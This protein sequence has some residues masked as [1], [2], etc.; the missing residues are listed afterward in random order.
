MSNDSRIGTPD[1][2]EGA[3]RIG[4]PGQCHLVE[5]L[6]EDRWLQHPAVPD[7]T[8]VLRR[9]PLL[10]ADDGA[11]DD[12][13]HQEHRRAGHDVRDV[14]QD[15]RRQRQFAAQRVAN[16]FWNTGTMKMIMAEKMTNMTD[17][18]TAG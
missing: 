11:D 2:D 10:D 18:T 16:R 9:D 8:T 13:D 1:A 17:I 5:Q 14:D 12:G 7:P 6:A 4:R 15:L 3:Q